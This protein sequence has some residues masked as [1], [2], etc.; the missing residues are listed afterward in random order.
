MTVFWFLVA[1]YAREDDQEEQ[2]GLEKYD[3]TL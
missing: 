3:G 2:R 1:R